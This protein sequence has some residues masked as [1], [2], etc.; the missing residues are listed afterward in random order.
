MGNRQ[1]MFESGQQS[2]ADANSRATCAFMT[3][4]AATI[5]SNSAHQAT[6]NNKYSSRQMPHAFKAAIAPKSKF[7]GLHRQHY[8]YK[9]ATRSR[10]NVTMMSAH[11]PSR[12]PYDNPGIPPPPRRSTEQG[13]SNFERQ[14]APRIDQISI[15][16][17]SPQ[18]YRVRISDLD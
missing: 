12:D 6:I 7:Y 3:S 16:V 9:P 13:S 5:M 2:I 14:M 1:S 8:S 10:N 18:E 11:E 15:E 4:R 17:V